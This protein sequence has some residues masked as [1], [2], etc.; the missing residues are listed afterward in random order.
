M[1]ASRRAKLLTS[2]L[3]S[4]F[5]GT[6]FALRTD[7]ELV[8][9]CN[10]GDAGAWDALIER[11]AP[12]IYSVSV[13]MGMSPEDSADVF[14]DVCL[15]LLNHLDE[16]RET[17]KLAGWLA[18]SARREVWRF[19]RRRKAAALVP[20]TETDEETIFD[21]GDRSMEVRLI[22]VEE[23]FRMTQALGALPERCRTL[24]TLLYVNDPPAAYTHVSDALGLPMGSIG[25]TRARCLQ[26]LKKIFEEQSD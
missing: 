10:K 20:L 18:T 6:P 8:V 9:A 22:A 1:N 7:A 23:G 21:S 13:R 5:T 12:L 24:L 2:R 26:R 14:Q 15:Q 11:F 17:E 4:S 25:P 16:L 19:Q 3:V